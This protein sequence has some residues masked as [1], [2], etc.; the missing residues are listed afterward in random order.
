MLRGNRGGSGQ[1]RRRTG[2]GRS[3]DRGENGGTRGT[4]RVVLICEWSLVSWSDRQSMADSGSGPAGHLP[5][6]AA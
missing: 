4:L 6:K 2:R 1:G 3:K 5:A